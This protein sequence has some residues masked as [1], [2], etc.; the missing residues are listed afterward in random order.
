MK[1]CG[2]CGS[3]RLELEEIGED[4]YGQ[5]EDYICEECGETTRFPVN[6]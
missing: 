5:Y 2:E 1:Q 3:N 6:N 4:E